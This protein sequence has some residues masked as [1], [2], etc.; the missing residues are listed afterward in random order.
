M[1]VVLQMNRENDKGSA[2]G[3]ATKSGVAVSL[4]KHIKWM[5]THRN[6]YTQ[7]HTVVHTHTCMYLHIHVGTCSCIL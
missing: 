1:F 6:T 5:Y 4:D 2:T 7:I 3:K